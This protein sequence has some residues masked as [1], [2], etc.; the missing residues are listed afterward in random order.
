[1]SSN[2]TQ[3]TTAIVKSTCMWNTPLLPYKRVNIT[4]HRR[5]LAGATTMSTVILHRM[6][7]ETLKYVHVCL[8]KQDTFW[9]PFMYNLTPEIWTPQ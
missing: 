3:L 1:M 4:V 7:S 8:N 6:K 2:L 5:E 9:F